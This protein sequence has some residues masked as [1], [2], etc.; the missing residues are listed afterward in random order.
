MRWV[1]GLQ[2]SGFRVF[3]QQ[4]HVKLVNAQNLVV[5]PYNWKL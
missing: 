4:S 2:M 3:M 5:K 1:S